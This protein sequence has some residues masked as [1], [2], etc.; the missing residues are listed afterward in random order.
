M[1]RSPEELA[2]ALSALD[3]G[4]VQSILTSSCDFA[5][6]ARRR[7]YQ[8]VEVN[9]GVEQLYE[10]RGGITGARTDSGHAGTVSGQPTNGPA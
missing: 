5:E 1:N 3:A 9:A 6:L 10:I 8:V 7:G 2:P 4:E